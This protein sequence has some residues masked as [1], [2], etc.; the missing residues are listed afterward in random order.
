[1]YM[2]HPLGIIIIRKRMKFVPLHLLPP[3]LCA[4]A[5]LERL[6][7]SVPVEE[8]GEPKLTGTPTKSPYVKIITENE[9]LRKDLKKVRECPTY[10]VWCTSA[11]VMPSLDMYMQ[12]KL[13]KS[14]I[15]ILY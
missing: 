2:Y 8:I 9:R 1:M 5:E 6:Q 13:D 3:F 7:A 4:Q 11:C 14:I 12:P 15:I 10:Q